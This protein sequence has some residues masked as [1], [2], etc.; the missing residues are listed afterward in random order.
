MSIEHKTRGDR[1]KSAYHIQ[2]PKVWHFDPHNLFNY[3]QS[4]L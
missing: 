1:Y 4:I 3:Y 2:Y